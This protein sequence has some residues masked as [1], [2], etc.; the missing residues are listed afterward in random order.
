M[1]NNLL[2]IANRAENTE[3]MLR[4]LNALITIN[5]DQAT[6][7]TRILRMI[8]AHRLKQFDLALTDARWLMEQRPDDVD[9]QAVEELI[10]VIESKD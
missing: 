2:G 4:Y 5:E 6:S 10:R 9:L 1:L 7:R 8:T 3:Q